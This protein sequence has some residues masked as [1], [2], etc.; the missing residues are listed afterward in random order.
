MHQNNNSIG[1]HLNFKVQS[2]V[3]GIHYV[4]WKGS[5]GLSCQGTHAADYRRCTNY[6]T[7]LSKQCK[8]TTRVFFALLHYQ[9]GRVLGPQLPANVAL[10]TV[11]VAY[12]TTV[13][14][15]ATTPASLSW[16]L[17]ELG[18]QSLLS[19]AKRR[20]SDQYQ[21]HHTRAATLQYIVTQ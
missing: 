18:T 3:A 20:K 1:K 9:Q 16:H 13:V 21:S 11:P 17:L 19:R 12:S 10:A 7:S 8:M 2:S 15:T 4:L 14:T 5:R 6:K